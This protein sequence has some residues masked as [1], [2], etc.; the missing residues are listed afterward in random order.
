MRTVL[1]KEFN[2]Y[3]PNNTDYR[4]FPLRHRNINLGQEE[5]SGYQAVTWKKAA[6]LSQSKKEKSLVL[7]ANSTKIKYVKTFNSL[8][9]SAGAAGK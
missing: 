8:F 7:A 3:D 5:L 2:S 1:V 4:I 9:L 6:I